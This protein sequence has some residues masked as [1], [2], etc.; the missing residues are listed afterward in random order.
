MPDF[1]HSL[2]GLDLNTGVKK[3]AGLGLDKFCP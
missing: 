3:V 2:V 1:G